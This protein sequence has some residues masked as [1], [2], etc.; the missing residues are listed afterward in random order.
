MSAEAVLMGNYFF[1]FAI[2]QSNYP[3]KLNDI[4]VCI[5]FIIVFEI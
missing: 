1:F 3:Y 2:Y 4:P 5:V